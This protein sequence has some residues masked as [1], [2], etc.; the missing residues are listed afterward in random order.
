MLMTQMNTDKISENQRSISA[1]CVPFIALGQSF[2]RQLGHFNEGMK[3]ARAKGE[4]TARRR[5]DHVP[6]GAG[7]G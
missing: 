2:A 5:R 3:D 7:D 4:K 1:I 6:C